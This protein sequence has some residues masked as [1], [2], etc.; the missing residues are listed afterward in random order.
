MKGMPSLER[1]GA[2]GAKTVATE[3][4][5]QS[6][7]SGG[8]RYI[9]DENVAEQRDFGYWFSLYFVLQSTQKTLTGAD[10]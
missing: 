1:A 6:T 7:G 10:E 5:E 3:C 8:L 2:G 4:V 9:S